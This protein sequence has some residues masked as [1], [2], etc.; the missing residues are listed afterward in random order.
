MQPLSERTYAPTWSRGNTAGTFRFADSYDRSYGCHGARETA[1]ADRLGYC[2]VTEG[3]VA[4]V[5]GHMLRRDV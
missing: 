2:E 3:G 1:A 5:S 4:A